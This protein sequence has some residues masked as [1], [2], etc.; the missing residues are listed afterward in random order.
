[1]SLLHW[2][3]LIVLGLWGGVVLAETVIEF[4]PR[5]EDEFRVTARLHY[6]IDLLIEIPI[7]IGVVVTGFLLTLK[8]WPPSDLLLIKI[9]AAMIAVGVNLYCI[10]A[11]IFRYRNREDPEVLRAYSQNIRWAW[12]GVPFAVTA[13]YIGI[14]YFMP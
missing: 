13:L 10:L 5:S 14:R 4:G 2:L 11:V 1:M 7:L 12:V 9:V 6:W 3:H 8:V